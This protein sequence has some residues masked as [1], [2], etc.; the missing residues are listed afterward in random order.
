[1]RDTVQLR[2]NLMTHR[3]R[4][5][6]FASGTATGGGSGFENLCRESALEGGPFAADIVAAISTHRDGGVRRHA[7]TY[8][9][10]FLHFTGPW[11]AESYRTIAQKTGADFYALAG[12]LKPVSG[13]DPR[14]TFNIHPGPLPDFGGKGMYGRHVHEAVLNAYQQGRLTHT[15]I[16]IHFVT[17]KYDEGPIFCKVQIAIKEGDT[18]ESLEKRVKKLEH[19]Y[20]PR[21]LNYAMRGMVGWDGETPHSLKATLGYVFVNHEK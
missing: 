10:P 9:V 21:Y 11:T 3:P 18:P 5:A 12:W 17:E 6:V 7:E 8:R 15:E 16:N 13:L 20:F 14:K 2:E 1:M 19:L 4:L